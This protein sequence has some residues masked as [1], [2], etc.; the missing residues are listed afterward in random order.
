MHA[1]ATKTPPP[2]RKWRVRLG[3]IVL[4]IWHGYYRM[5]A[6]D[7]GKQLGGKRCRR[8]WLNEYLRRDTK[9]AMQSTDHFKR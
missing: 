8:V 1:R 9:L 6:L 5:K 7:E 4:Q 2:E 3:H